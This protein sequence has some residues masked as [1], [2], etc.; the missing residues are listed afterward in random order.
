[1]T[2]ILKAKEIISLHTNQI[3]AKIKE[4]STPPKLKVIL[5]GDNPSSKI[6]VNRKKEFCEKIGAV[7]EIIYRDDSF[8][9]EELK[10]LL[11]EINHDNSVHGCL[12]QL[13][14]PKQ[15]ENFDFQHLISPKKDVDGFH[16]RNIFSIYQN[17]KGDFLLPCTPVGIIAML[18]HYN[19]DVSGKNVCVIGRSLIV[20][21][22]LSM[23][24]SNMN[25]TVTIC[26]SKTKNLQELTKSSELIIT[27]VGSPKF[28]NSD[29]FK[30]DQ[31]QV[32]I[33]VGISRLP[34]GQ[35]CGDVDFDQVK[36]M[37]KAITPVPGGVGPMTILSLAKNL[38]KATQNQIP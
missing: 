35:I 15:F 11:T 16:Q 29:F 12:V 10:A 33:D 5:V 36:G 30:N 18:K 32:I 17:Q 23:M 14:L 31:S 27:A 28:L 37:V 24:L 19:I 8:S 9:K 2:L 13:P 7:C 26:H 3:Q 22:P 25:A 38:L 6:Y 21:K 1:M 34:S 4:L 20:G